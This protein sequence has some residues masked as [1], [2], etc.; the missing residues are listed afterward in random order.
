[1]LVQFV[2]KGFREVVGLVG[3]GILN[4]QFEQSST[5]P[6]TH[7]HPSSP[8]VEILERMCRMDR[9][10]RGKNFDGC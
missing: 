5:P 10:G 7:A 8:H 4:P 3:V 6:P 9:E 2:L 1:M